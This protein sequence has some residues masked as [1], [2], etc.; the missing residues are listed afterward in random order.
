MTAVLEESVQRYT[1]DPESGR[2]SATVTATAGTGPTRLSGGK[3]NW[4]TDLP[5]MIGGSNL[6]PG[7][8]GYLLGALAGCAVAFIKDTLAPQFAVRLNEVRAVAS[9]TSDLG[10]LLG[11]PGS[12]PN[13][14]GMAIEIVIDSP[15]EEDKVERVKRAW[16]ERCPIYLA[17][18]D[19]HE[20]S[21]T[22]A[23]AG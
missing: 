4:D 22:F 5:P 15:D 7:P 17:L 23:A 1:A 6:A 2:V 9:C 21:V 8:T 14:D 18:V 10:G 3:F 11:V 13:L 12:R 20:V 19:P 16:V